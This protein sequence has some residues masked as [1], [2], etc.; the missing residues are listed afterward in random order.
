M[1]RI[2]YDLRAFF[3][4]PVG[5]PFRMTGMTRTMIEWG[6]ELRDDPEVRCI[7]PGQEDLIRSFLADGGYPEL[8][9]S[10]VDSTLRG[11]TRRI[12]G[13]VHRDLMHRD[14]LSKIRRVVANEIATRRFPSDTAKFLKSERTN[15]SAI[16]F[17]P[18]VRR[19]PRNLPPHWTAVLNLY[20]LIPVMFEPMPPIL[21][22]ECHAA[23][24]SNTAIGGHFI[25]NSAYTRHALHSKYQ[26]PSERIHL[27]QLGVTQSPVSSPSPD[28]RRQ[29]RVARPYFVCICGGIDRRKNVGGTISEF[30]RFLT[31]SHSPHELLLV[32]PTDHDIQKLNL[33]IP[34]ALKNRIHGTGHI[35]D[36]EVNELLKC[37]TGGIY[38]SLHEGFGL[39]PLEFMKHGVPVIASNLTSI[40]EA[41]GDAALLVDPLEPGAAAAAML[42]LAEDPTLAAELSRRSLH[43]ASQFSWKASTDR[44][45]T[46]LRAILESTRSA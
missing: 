8:A 40:P 34:D 21:R 14:P 1:N 28:E 25:V 23:V 19:M 37:A 11:A 30:I 4:I 32:G 43:R 41:V 6:N 46:T 15:E 18:G 24:L 33:R 45:K 38:L 5:G 35:T 39:P 2:Y 16:Y 26:I 31:A 42:Q 3:Q 7:A 17:L 27:V 29:N 20:D 10:I 9:N 22:R 44:L 13:A 36:G 12:V